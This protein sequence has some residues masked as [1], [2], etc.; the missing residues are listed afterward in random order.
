MGRMSTERKLAELLDLY[1]GA[2]FKKNYAMRFSQLIA[3]CDLHRRTPLTREIVEHSGFEQCGA[4]ECCSSYAIDDRYGL[5][6]HDDDAPLVLYSDDIA[7]E[8]ATLMPLR[9]V[10]D[11]ESLLDILGI[12]KPIRIPKPLPEVEEQKEE[13]K[14]T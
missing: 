7:C 5:W 9:T 14:N 8:S 12:D 10:A 2:E 4:T 1:G 3:V 6:F 11:L 13:Q